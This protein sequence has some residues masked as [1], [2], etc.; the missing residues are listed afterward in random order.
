MY[1]QLGFRNYYTEVFR[2]IVNFLVKW[3]KAARFLL[4]KNCSVNLLGKKGR[5]IELDAYVEAEVVQPL[6]NYVSG[7]TSVLM[8]ERLMANLDMLKYLRRAYMEKDGFDVHPTTSHSV[9]SSFP[10]QLKGA[11]FCVKKG[12]FERNDREEVEC[13]PLDNGC[14]A[15]GKVP[16]N[17]IDVVSKGKEK[18]KSNFKAKLYECF[19]DLRYKILMS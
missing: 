4:Q 9:P 1:A 11:W 7:H 13:Y 18:I 8:C 2:H 10:D 15:S 17:L 14:N 5:G 12:F 19:P 3:P 6:K 16:K